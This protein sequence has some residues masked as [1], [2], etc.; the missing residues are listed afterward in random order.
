MK[1]INFDY[2]E[3]MQDALDPSATTDLVNMCNKLERLKM[4]NM[5]RVPDAVKSSLA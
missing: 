3:Y 4:T 1:E 2:F 5:F